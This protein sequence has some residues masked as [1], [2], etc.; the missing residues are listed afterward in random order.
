MMRNIDVCAMKNPIDVED[1]AEIKK[2]WL[3]VST[4]YQIIKESEEGD[5]G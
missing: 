1:E 3:L 5:D 4:N 2:A